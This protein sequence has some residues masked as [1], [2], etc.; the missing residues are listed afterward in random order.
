MK[1]VPLSFL[2]SP[3]SDCVAYLIAGTSNIEDATFYTEV[4]TPHIVHVNAHIKVA[5]IRTEIA[6]ALTEAST[7]HMED[8]KCHKEGETSHTAPVQ[9]ALKMQHPTKRM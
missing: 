6:T 3:Y 8:M 7:G 2:N 1:Y 4:K 9:H 5:T